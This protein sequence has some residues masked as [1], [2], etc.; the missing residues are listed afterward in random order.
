LVKKKKI[1]IIGS[2]ISGLVAGAY[3]ALKGH[4]VKIFEQFYEVGGVMAPF[5]DENGYTW[6]LGQL[7]MEG[8]GPDE[9]FGM[10]LGELG[11]SDKLEIL[12]DER[13]YIFPDFRLDKPKEYGGFK[14]RL[15]RLKEISP[16]DAKGLEKYWKYY[17]QFTKI[18][19]FARRMDFTKGLKSFI[20]KIRMYLNL[21]PLAS[22]QNMTAAE[23]MKYFFKS[24]KVGMV[25]IS[26]LADFFVR[27]SQFMG[28]G[29][30]ALNPE[31]SFDRRMPAKISKNRQQLYFYSI[32]NGCHTITDALGERIEELGGKIHLNTPITKINVENGKAAGVTTQDGTFHKAD[33]VISS[34]S[35]SEI[36]LDLFDEGVLSEEYKQQ[37]KEVPLMDS[38]FMVHLGLDPE[39]DARKYLNCVCTYCY[40]MYD[41]EGGVERALSG[42]YHEG[43]DGFVIHVP[44]YHSP[45]MAPEGHTAMT[46]YTICPNVLKE[47]DWED[48]REYFADKLLEYSEKYLP[49]LRKHVKVRRIITPLDWQKRTMVKHHAFGGLAPIM[50]KSG[51]PHET[52]VKDFWFIGH[53]SE[54]GGGVPATAIPVRRLMNKI[55]K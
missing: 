2:G 39:F 34:G 53:M 32:K 40:G 27:P 9:P 50:G 30:A 18:M 21:L 37:V 11:V 28:L 20:N 19:T 52:P 6:D 22:K 33:M 7:L 31:P 25:F 26:I 17:K 49:D 54:S 3:A 47:G 29:V 51:L 35:P 13:E 1:A 24:D 38:I 10:L 8:L 46:I 36:C 16:E 42:D 15:D 12:R 43:K 45:E 23:L 4:E 41:L 14:W 44:T 55:L 48:K 5:K